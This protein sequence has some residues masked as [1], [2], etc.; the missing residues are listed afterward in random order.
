MLLA[1]DVGNTHTVYAVYGADDRPLAVL[2]QQTRPQQTEDEMLAFLRQTLRYRGLEID[3]IDEV[4]AS[5]VVPQLQFSL[6][7]LAKA[8]SA[9]FLDVGSQVLLPLCPCEVERP[10]EV[11]ADRMVNSIAFFHHFSKAGIVVDFGT[12]TTFDLVSATGA[13][14]G[15]V[16]AP[17]VD[18]SVEALRAAAARLPNISIKA[19][20]NVVGKN[21]KQAMQ[22]GVFY[23]YVSMIDGVVTRIRQEVGEELYCVATGGLAPLIAT[24]S[25]TI[26]EVLPELTLDGLR[27][28]HSQL[29]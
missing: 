27:V 22:S 4:I 6:K 1:I 5:S 24:S 28:I 7:Q 21:T 15:G 13:Y 17:G 26:A 2:R 10:E 14:Q 25:Q 18:S 20:E 23:G 16:I 29:K 12:A 3:L 19:P 8:L 9:D 11:G